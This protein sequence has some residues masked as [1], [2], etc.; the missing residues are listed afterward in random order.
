M[1]M[2]VRQRVN[3]GSLLICLRFFPYVMFVSTYLW[4]MRSI[5]HM[6]LITWQALFR[7]HTGQWIIFECVY[8]SNN[9]AI[10]HL[11]GESEFPVHRCCLCE[12]GLFGI[13]SLGAL[14][15]HCCVITVNSIK[16][17]LTHRKSMVKY[18]VYLRGGSRC[19]TWRKI[20][21]L[22]F[23]TNSAGVYFKQWMQLK[24]IWYLRR[25][26]VCGVCL[27]ACIIVSC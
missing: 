4:I 3:D 2:S 13:A 24:V 11:S 12:S 9:W 23:A 16:I 22:L 21:W 7:V 15:N 25:Y 8:F 17:S 18:N 6:L 19:W 27:A 5:S 20:R 1:A 14:K 10:F 26:R